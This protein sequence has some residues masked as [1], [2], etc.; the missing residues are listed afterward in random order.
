VTDQDSSWRSGRCSNHTMKQ[1]I[2]YETGI[3]TD[4]V[5]P[6]ITDEYV[7]HY[8]VNITALTIKPLK[9]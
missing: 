7:H 1:M 8:H 3:S 5:A 6:V 9:Q 2:N 4:C